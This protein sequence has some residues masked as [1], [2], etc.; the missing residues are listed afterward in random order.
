M[1]V[2]SNTPFAPYNGASSA[3]AIAA[4]TGRS[5]RGSLG[6]FFSIA[7]SD[8]FALLGSLANYGVQINALSG[9]AP[10]D[11]IKS[12][13][14]DNSNNILPVILYFNDTQYSITV[15]GG[16]QAWLPVFTLAQQGIVFIRG[17]T[18]QF[19]SVGNFATTILF[20]NIDAVAFINNPGGP[21]IG[22]QTFVSASWEPASPG[23]VTQLL[24]T[25]PGPGFMT[26]NSFRII[27][28]PTTTNENTVSLYIAALGGLYSVPMP[29]AAAVPVDVLDYP[30]LNMRIA[31]QDITAVTSGVNP[32]STGSLYL[33]AQLS[34]T[35]PV[36]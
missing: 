28:G 22:T 24:L 8:Y 26:V 4:E 13:Y 21:V 5:K 15:A 35:Y 3:R 18:A 25:N 30:N 36:P 17:M 11:V 34:Y 9:S 2:S 32:W 27:Q 12:A 20:M 1:G 33:Y 31:A 10:L 29:F 16:A 7:W 14:I 6:N 23:P 19:N